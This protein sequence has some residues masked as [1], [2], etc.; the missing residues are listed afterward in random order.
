MA[1]E[2]QSYKIMSDMEVCM[3]QRD[4][5]EFSHVE[6]M[7]HIDIH[8]CFLNV[9][10]DQTSDVSMVRQWLVH[11]RSSDIDV[12]DNLH[13]DGRAQLSHCEIKSVSIS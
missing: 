10:G 12:K 2:R 5:T 9:Y 7:T 4:V 3:K 8:R 1:T 13:P 11:F 6:K